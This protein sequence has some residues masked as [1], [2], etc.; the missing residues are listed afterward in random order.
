MGVTD[1]NYQIRELAEIAAEIVPDCRIAYAEDAG[2]DK[3][4]Y[5][6][7]CDKIRHVLFQFEPQWD[8]RKGAVELYRAYREGRLALEEFEGPRYQ[9]IGHIKKLIA[10]GIIDETLRHR[11]I[12]RV[13]PSP[14]YGGR[15]NSCL[16]P[17]IPWSLRNPLSNDRR[18][19]L[20]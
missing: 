4:C 1:H 19:W 16:A 3:R 13:H 8:A 9:R 7:N 17:A 10:D 15:E 18:R 14:V 6:V 11:E 2:P 12:R 5:R 20:S